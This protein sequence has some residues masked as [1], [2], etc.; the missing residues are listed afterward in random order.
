M[1][2]DKSDDDD[3][4]D[5][6]ALLSMPQRAPPLFINSPLLTNN[7]AIGQRPLVM[8]A[9]ISMSVRSLLMI[10]SA[11]PGQK[12][13]FLFVLS[14]LSGS[15]TSRR[16]STRSSPRMTRTGSTCARPRWPAR[17]TSARAPVS[18]ASARYCLRREFSCGYSADRHVSPSYPAHLPPNTAPRRIFRHPPPSGASMGRIDIEV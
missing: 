11:P 2:I 18:A 4:D 16:A 5:D 10:M 7:C 12:W 3:D 13:S 15:T 6:K 1:M 17:S 14:L 9:A 8:S